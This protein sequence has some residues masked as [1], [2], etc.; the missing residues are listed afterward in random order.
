LEGYE[1]KTPYIEDAV[2]IL[3]VVIPLF[4]LPAGDGKGTKYVKKTKK[5]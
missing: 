5:K 3:F 4:L 1:L 2:P